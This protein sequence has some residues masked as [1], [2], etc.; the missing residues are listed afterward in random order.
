[1]VRGKIKIEKDKLYYN[2]ELAIGCQI[3]DAR[4]GNNE[5]GFD[6]KNDGPDKLTKKVFFTGVDYNFVDNENR[7]KVLINISS[8]MVVELEK[9][10]WL[11]VL[12]EESKDISIG[13]VYEVMKF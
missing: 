7:E 2:L 9:Y 10:R 12:W 1:M 8:K 6:V 11:C 3:L 4:V 5:I 13:H